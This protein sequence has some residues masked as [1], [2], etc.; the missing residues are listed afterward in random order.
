MSGK[1]IPPYAR[2]RILILHKNGNSYSKIS[3]EL[4]LSGCPVSRQSV[5]AFVKK[6]TGEKEDKKPLKETNYQRKPEMVHFKYIDSEMA[7][8]DELCAAGKMQAHVLYFYILLTTDELA[9]VL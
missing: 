2:E 6:C 1:R 9:G 4:R 3:R 8:N 7:R 5:S